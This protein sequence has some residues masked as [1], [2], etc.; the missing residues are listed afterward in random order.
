MQ[1]ALLHGVVAELLKSCDTLAT[2]QQDETTDM[3][4]VHSLNI[5]RA[6]VVDAKLAG[7]IRCYLARITIL[8]VDSFTSPVWAL[9]NAAMQLFGEWLKLFYLYSH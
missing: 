6:L 2:T 4:Q 5:L 8:C 9:R 7:S 1:S 3:P